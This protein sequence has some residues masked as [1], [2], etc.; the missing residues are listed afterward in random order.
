MPNRDVDDTILRHLATH[1]FLSAADLEVRWGVATA[2]MARALARLR[3]A[4]LVERVPQGDD[5]TFLY[6]PTGD[7][8]IAAA[9]ST[10]IALGSLCRIYGLDRRQLLA[11]LPLLK[12]L[13]YAQRFVMELA[14]ALDEGGQGRLTFYKS[15]PLH[16]H[17]A[18]GGPRGEILLDG[19]GR[20]TV[21]RATSGATYWFGLLWDGDGTLPAVGLWHQLDRLR[22][23]RP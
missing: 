12:R 18:R 1:P 4:G 8:A 21:G 23:L 13:V 17:A 20:I 11:R 9:A 16:W 10:G 15:G 2:T 7:G 6:V 3:D 5:K 22:A 19:M 14:A